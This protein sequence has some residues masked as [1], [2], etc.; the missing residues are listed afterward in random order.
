MNPVFRLLLI[1]VVGLSVL[2][3]AVLVVSSEDGVS[4]PALIAGG[5]LAAGEDDDSVKGSLSERAA[6]IALGNNANAVLSLDLIC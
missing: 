1:A 4:S 2:T 5:E 6:K 3:G